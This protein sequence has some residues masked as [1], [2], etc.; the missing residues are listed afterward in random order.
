MIKEIESQ[1]TSFHLTP[2][3]PLRYISLYHSTSRNVIHGAQRRFSA[4]NSSIATIEKSD[5]RRMTLSTNT[6]L[7]SCI[8]Q[9]FYSSKSF[10]AT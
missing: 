10:K 9:N 6:T 1:C 3:I 7:E 2:H 5:Y 8:P 4:K